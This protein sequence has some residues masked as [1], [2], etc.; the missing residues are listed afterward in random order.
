MVNTMSTN[1]DFLKTVDTADL[2]VELEF[3]LNPDSEDFDEECYD[4]EYAAA[5]KAE[6]ESRLNP[7]I[8]N[9]LELSDSDEEQPEDEWNPLW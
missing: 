3:T 8:L 2:A 6:Y 5:V 1:Y 4:A 7:S 9:W